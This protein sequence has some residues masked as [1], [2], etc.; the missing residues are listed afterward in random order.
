MKSRG[1]KGR[2]FER[3]KKSSKRRWVRGRGGRR[4]YGRGEEER[5]K[6]R[7]IESGEKSKRWRGQGGWM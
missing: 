2:V 5:K 4:R 7:M 6:G 1:K 3:G